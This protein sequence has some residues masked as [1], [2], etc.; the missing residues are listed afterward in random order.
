MVFFGLGNPTR[1]YERTRHNLG[2]MVLDAL[3]RKCRLRFRNRGSWQEACCRLGGNDC[4]L[5]KPMTY[6]NDSGRPVR[7]FLSRHA[8]GRRKDAGKTQ[9]RR[10]KDAGDDSRERSDSAVPFLVV[11]DDLAL[12]FGRIR[13]RPSGSDGGHQGMASIIAELNTTDFPRVR[14]GIGAPQVGMDA[15][16]YVLS[17][18][19]P[20]EQRY[21]PDVIAA[22][23]DALRVIAEQSLNAAMNEFNSR[24]LISEGTVNK[25]PIADSRQP[26][27]DRGQSPTTQ[28]AQENAH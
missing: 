12:P 1:E 21:L 8:G 18:F 2:F 15:A 23:R 19:Q 17:E 24:E 26:T 16:M 25:G 27:A 6:M 5:V 7:E 3:A 14:L 28:E 13:I 4:F 20:E 11:F 10:R 9:K 22:G